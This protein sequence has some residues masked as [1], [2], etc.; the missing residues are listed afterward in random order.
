[1]DKILHVLKLVS[2]EEISRWSLK[3]KIFF[4]ILVAIYVL[5]PLDLIPDLI[6]GLGLVDDA[7]VVGYT[8][9][10]IFYSWLKRRQE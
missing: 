7:V 3:K 4:L 10:V 6:P 5:S 2:P 9:L 8:A 1:M